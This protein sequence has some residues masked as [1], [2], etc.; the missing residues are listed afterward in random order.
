MPDK[1][2]TWLPALRPLQTNDILLIDHLQVEDTLTTMANN[3]GTV[4]RYTPW[5]DI[6]RSSGTYIY[7]VA[8]D[9]VGDAWIS[10]DY[11]LNHQFK[12]F[13]RVS[14]SAL[15]KS[16]RFFEAQFS[17]PWSRDFPIDD[18]LSLDENFQ[19]LVAFLHI[20]S[21]DNLLPPSA[22][23]ILPEIA[24]L[25]DQ[26]CF[27]GQLPVWCEQKLQARLDQYFPMVNDTYS[28]IEMFHRWGQ[29]PPNS[30]PAVLHTAYLLNLPKTFAIA[31]RQM[32]WLMSFEHVQI[33]LPRDLNLLPINFVDSFKM[34]ATRLRN[35]LLHFLPAVFF[36]DTH[37][38][39]DPDCK[40]PCRKCDM[41]PMQ[42][43]WY[44]EV[45]RKSATLAY[46]NEH[47]GPVLPIVDIFTG[48]VK[49][50]ASLELPRVDERV[51]TVQHPFPCGRFRLRVVDFDEVE[52]LT[53][54]YGA[55][56]GLCLK[57]V[58]SGRF[59]YDR[60]VFFIAG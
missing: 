6:S 52:M 5:C 37:S 23:E 51:P 12:V 32:M 21:E 47:Q 54:V 4:S 45:V 8:P 28:D 30:C 36:P 10:T 11:P 35:D 34:E 53:L 14:R 25:C 9:G 20:C 16:T 17:D 7:E 39:Q 3:I 15:K 26:Y 60:Y 46:E 29:L 59:K 41:V 43:R 13:I 22:D 27:D 19:E 49:R 57:C 48:Y 24:V 44:I 56:G 50:M 2:M 1:D 40:R 33:L 18:P 31:S 55:I 38:Q 42:A 58:K